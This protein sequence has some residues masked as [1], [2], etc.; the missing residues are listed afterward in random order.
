MI[1]IQRLLTIMVSL[2]FDV[3]FSLFFCEI[4]KILIIIGTTL[5]EK[6]INLNDIFYYLQP[7]GCNYLK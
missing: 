7:V 1:V 5:L 4:C 6:I 3:D 2:C